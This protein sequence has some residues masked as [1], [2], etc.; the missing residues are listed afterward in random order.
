MSLKNFSRFENDLK[1]ILKSFNEFHIKVKYSEILTKKKVSLKED[2][3]S[4]SGPNTTEEES[5]Q[6][7]ILK[8]DDFDEHE[9]EN[10]QENEDEQKNERDNEQENEQENERETGEGETIKGQ[11]T[12]E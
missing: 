4:S 6:D 9:H 2:S 7:D 3:M 11:L 5:S 8:L 1:I 12:S 10:D